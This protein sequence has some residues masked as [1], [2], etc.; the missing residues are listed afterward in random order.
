MRD[1]IRG[2]D[3]QLIAFRQGRIEREEIGYADNV[4]IT[5]A[6]LLASG[7]NAQ[8][9]AELL[10]IDSSVISL[11]YRDIILN[12]EDLPFGLDE[13]TYRREKN[14]V[15]AD[16]RTRGC[17]VKGVIEEVFSIQEAVEAVGNTLVNETTIKNWVRT[18]SNDYD[19]MITMPAAREF[20]VGN[21]YSLTRDDAMADQALILQHDREENELAS[22]RREI[23]RTARAQ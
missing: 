15:R 2:Y 20:Q 17:V 4:K 10:G 1:Y 12:Q 7:E 21:T 8:H 6:T 5:V 14:A 23:A 19:Y 11:W 22:Q 9:I 13:F 3:E 16:A 18:Y